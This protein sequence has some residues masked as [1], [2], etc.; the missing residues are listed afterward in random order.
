MVQF[1]GLIKMFKVEPWNSILQ[2]DTERK[3]EVRVST[4]SM[5]EIVLLENFRISPNLSSDRERIPKKR[6]QNNYNKFHL[7]DE[8]WHAVISVVRI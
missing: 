6:R 2:R 4:L 3:H 7:E 1:E 5:L 8:K